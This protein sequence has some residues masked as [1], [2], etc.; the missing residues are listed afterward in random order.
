MAAT[1][2]AVAP[3][4][5]EGAEADEE[6]DADGDEDPGPGVR[7]GGGVE[8]GGERGG[9]GG[10]AG[11]GGFF[12]HGFSFWGGGGGWAVCCCCVVFVGRM[13]MARYGAR[14]FSVSEQP[15]KPGDGVGRGRTRERI[16]GEAS[17]EQKQPLRVTRCIIPSFTP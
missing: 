16:G 15:Q 5:E 12:F 6:D 1:T 13:G 3:V 11:G 17:P 4:G 7:G 9:S 14:V 2:A 8:V 10:T